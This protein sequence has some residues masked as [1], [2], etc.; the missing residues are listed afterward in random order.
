M[1]ISANRIKHEY[2][3]GG[4]SHLLTGGFEY[5]F[6]ESISKVPSVYWKIV[7]RYYKWRS[8]NDILEYD[9]SPHP[10]KI[11]DVAPSVI[12]KESNRT[13]RIFNRRTKFG[14]VCGGDWDITGRNFTDL[15]PYEIGYEHFIEGK[16]WEETS[17]FPTLLEKAESG[18][19]NTWKYNSR[20]DILNWLNKFDKLYHRIKNDGYR[21][22]RNLIDS[23]KGANGGL[24]LDTLDEVTV[25]IGRDGELLFADGVHRL[26]IAKLLDLDSIPVVFLV[27]H[28][29]WMETR[30]SVATQD[31]VFDHP[32][33]RD[34]KRSTSPGRWKPKINN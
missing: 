1:D 17:L 33:L 23:P 2:S 11:E 9:Y 24:F 18:E 25:D 32:D 3:K 13:D 10:F 12:T 5:A 20:E 28:T 14:A 30:D 4:F 27:R 7:P 16:P 6:I 26:V 15:G 34:L 21:Q 31:D 8:S 22:H 19:Y 29:K